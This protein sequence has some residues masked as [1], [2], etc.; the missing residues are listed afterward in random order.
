MAR[1]PFVSG[2]PA[3][4]VKI[5]ILHIGTLQLM[6][7]YRSGPALQNVHPSRAYYSYSKE[8]KNISIL[9]IPSFRL[10]QLMIFP[11]RD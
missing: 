3:A 2:R 9:T 7:E 4:H 11:V 6:T 1:L 10:F 8:G 5:L